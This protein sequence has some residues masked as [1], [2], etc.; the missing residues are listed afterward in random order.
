MP[1]LPRPERA[2][3]WSVAASAGDGDALALVTRLCR[4]PDRGVALFCRAVV[5]AWLA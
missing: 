5:V 3:Q 2:S 4:E 1:E